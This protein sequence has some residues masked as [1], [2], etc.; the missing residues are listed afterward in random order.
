[1]W[2]A[3]E[4]FQSLLYLNVTLISGS[5]EL[6]REQVADIYPDYPVRLGALKINDPV[7]VPLSNS[8][9][10]G[11]VI[12]LQDW[13]TYQVESGKYM[14]SFDENEVMAFPSH[15]QQATSKNTLIL[16]YAQAQL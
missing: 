5:T 10:V 8:R 15:T 14:Y 11:K 3:V 12:G 6:L 2:V 1:M 9:A 16:F 13:L 7:L 4:P